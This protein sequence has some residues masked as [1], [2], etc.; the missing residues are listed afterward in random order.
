MKRVLAWALLALSLIGLFVVV[1]L[2][3]VGVID[4]DVLIAVALALTALD[5][6]ASATAAIWIAEK[7]PASPTG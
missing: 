6:T 1:P 5:G 7:D 2:W 4:G 3:V